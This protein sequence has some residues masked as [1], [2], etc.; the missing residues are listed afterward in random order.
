MH[1]ERGGW[2][3]KN[4]RVWFEK[5]GTFSKASWA[6]KRYIAILLYYRIVCWSWNVVIK[7]NYTEPSS[8]LQF[9]LISDND[10][11]EWNP[12]CYRFPKKHCDR[13]SV[14]NSIYLVVAGNTVVVGQQHHGMCFFDFYGRW[15]LQFTYDILQHMSMTIGQRTYFYWTRLHSRPTTLLRKSS[16]G[17][18]EAYN[19][20][21]MTARCKIDTDTQLLRRL[22]QNFWKTMI[23]YAFIG[24]I[25]WCSI[26]RNSLKSR[27]KLNYKRLMNLPKIQ[28]YLPKLD[29][30]VTS[31]QIF[32]FNKGL[33]FHGPLH[34][35]F[36][37][38]K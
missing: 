11:Q 2:P 36:Y 4:I 31:L 9:F 19:I 18:T 24:I 21:R 16:R 22:L 17:N 12:C 27:Q 33:L 32:F 15:T 20:M 30:V 13:I 34:L 38:I 28:R 5:K 37:Q 26:W 3:E 1:L 8:E 6:I 14:S 25:R 35:A 10:T 29:A 23:F 7:D